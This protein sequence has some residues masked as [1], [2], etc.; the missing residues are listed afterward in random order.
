MIKYQGVYPERM[1]ICGREGR[2]VVERQ[3]YSDGAVTHT[4][5]VE[6]IGGPQY[7]LH[8]S[9]VGELGAQLARHTA[10]ELLVDLEDALKE[11]AAIALDPAGV[12]QTAIKIF[13][14]KKEVR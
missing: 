11:A 4:L 12:C 5:T 2:L 9:S 7:S 13:A 1:M 10:A 14:L 8:C 3:R 6:V